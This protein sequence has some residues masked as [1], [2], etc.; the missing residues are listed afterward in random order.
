MSTT[1]GRS[2]GGYLWAVLE[3]VAGIAL[4]SIAFAAFIRAPQLGTNFPLFYST[5]MLP[6]M[7][8]MSVS[9]ALAQALNFS[10]PLLA[11]PSVTWLDAI[12]ARFILNVL[13]E[14]MVAYLIFTGIIAYYDTRVILDLPVIAEGFAL[15][16]A[17]ALGVGTL[18][19]FL[20]TRFPVWQRAWSILM[21]PLVLIS[22]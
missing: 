5:G 9:G 14:L 3:P 16:A 12:I 18:N 15:T 20:F 17:L 8:F 6:F 13:T 21:R 22:G 19:C 11:Y 10:R 7:L 2:P 4:M 1:Y